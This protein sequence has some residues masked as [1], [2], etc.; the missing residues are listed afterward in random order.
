M[1]LKKVYRKK[2]QRWEWALVSISKPAKVLYY[3]GTKKP[4]HEKFLKQ[5]RRVQYWKRFGSS[6]KTVIIRAHQ[7]KG[8]KGVRRHNRNIKGGIIPQN[9]RRIFDQIAKLPKE[10]GGDLDF[11]KKKKGSFNQLERFNTFIGKPGYVNLPDD[12]ESGWHIHPR[13]GYRTPSEDDMVNFIK[14]KGNQADII[15]SAKKGTA[16][17]LTKTKKS[18]KLNKLTKKKLFKQYNELYNKFEKEKKN[19]AKIE[20]GIVKQLKKDGFKVKE[21]KK[22]KSIRLPIKI[23]EPR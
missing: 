22:G 7:R 19:I 21:F 12:F 14:D 1:V 11:G 3:F 4:S 5:E 20:Q 9:Q 15:F 17:A 10:S 13:W 2:N 6:P 18:K 23:I 8:T 16:M